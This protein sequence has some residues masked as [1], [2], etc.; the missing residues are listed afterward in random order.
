MSERCPTC[1]HRSD[2]ELVHSTPPREP[3]RERPVRS[4]E[5]HDDLAALVDLVRRT[6]MQSHLRRVA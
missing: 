5:W 3:Q 6:V 2:D 4:D 1:G